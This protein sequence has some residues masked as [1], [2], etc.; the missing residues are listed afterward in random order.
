MKCGLTLRKPTKKLDGSIVFNVYRKINACV[1]GND[2]L[3]T[4]FD[5]LSA[6]WKE[7]DSLTNLTPCTCEASKKF[8]EHSDQI[9]L[10]QF[11]MGLDSSFSQVRSNILLREPL[12]S[13]KISFSIC[14]R[15]ES[16]KLSSS[17]TSPSEKHAPIGFF[18]NTSDSGKKKNNKNTLVCKNCGIKGHTIERCYKLIGYPKD[19]KG[20][21]DFQ[22]SNKQF[23]SNMT[24]ADLKES[25]DLFHFSSDQISKLLSLIGDKQKVEGV[26]ANMAGVFTKNVFQNIFRNLK[27]VI[28]SG[29]N[30]HMTSTDWNLKNVVDISDLK[31]K[32]DHPNGSSA[33]IVKIGDLPLSNSVTL[34]DVLVVPDFNVNLLSVHKVVKDNKIRVCFDESECYFQDLQKK[35]IVG[36]GSQ[37][38]GLYFID[39]GNCKEFKSNYSCLA[40]CYV[41]KS[42][43]HCRLGHPSEPVLTILQQ[44]LDI[45]PEL[46]PPCDVCHKAKQTRE[47][48]PLS[49]R[50]TS[51]LGDLIHLDVWGP[52]KV[53]TIEGYRYF[54]TVVDDFTRS[55][56]VFLLKSKSEV[57]G[58]IELFYNLLFT[59]FD[60]RIK[61]VRSDNGTEFTNN[62]VS[63]F[64]KDKG[65]IH[66]TTIAY[67]PQQNGIAERKHRHLLNVARSL[68]FQSGI[69]LQY[70]GDTILTAAYIINRTPSSVLKGKTLYEM[71]YSKLPSLTHLRIYG[72]LC[73]ATK[74]NVLN[75][76]ESRA[77]K[78]A[79]IGYSSFKKGYKLLSLETNIV[80]FSKDVQFYEH[81][82]PYKMSSDAT[83][84]KHMFD[85]FRHSHF[86]DDIDPVLPYD[87]SSDLKHISQYNN[88]AVSDRNVNFEHQNSD[89]ATNLDVGSDQE[90]SN[91][92]NS[93]DNP[94]HVAHLDFEGSFQN[95]GFDMDSLIGNQYYVHWENN[96]E[97]QPD[98]DFNITEGTSFD[99]SD[100][101]TV[102]INSD[103]RTTDY[104]LRRSSRVPKLPRK[105][106]DF[107]LD[108]KCKYGIERVVNYSHLDPDVRCFATN[109]NKSV[110]PKH[111]HE[112]CNDPNWVDAMNQEMNALYQNQTWEIT[113]LPS[114]RKPIGCKWIYKIKYKLNGDVDRYKA[115]LVAKEYSQ[116][117]G[118]D[119]D[120]TFAP[121]VKFV[122]I[123]CLITLAV[124]Q[125]WNLYQLD[126]NN[127]FLYGE[128]EEDVYMTL[129]Q[130][131][132]SKYEKKGLQT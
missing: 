105:L 112:A 29:A 103:P 8:S 24:Q 73:F 89:R 2:S 74:L 75:K 12:P 115:R 106:D 17:S 11:L 44:Y 1:Q 49:E 98:A 56:W 70:W 15:E 102:G 83:F 26:V 28:D 6:L 33:S 113:D 128:I 65:I 122:T 22:S 109:L 41:S 97:F 52:Y 76:F 126:I 21:N 51:S 100:S 46:L 62:N 92:S 117:E 104:D 88:P 20:K 124:N 101:E 119:F 4:Y 121:V 85:S 66:Q 94:D 95:S 13:V 40:K 31:L 47:S 9:K 19:N 86:F 35:M 57:F 14:S 23:S 37:T 5:K 84:S 78:C 90:L 114:G 99:N 118:I 81:I 125:S 50:K 107:V 39:E 48:F 91:S 58:N 27:W 93:L 82:L 131:Y 3:S 54:L 71:M 55:V 10:M 69:P 110:E 79:F 111:Y 18:A 42:T 64:F 32:V 45:G 30:H 34:F 120:E 108:G 16:H 59:Q 61:I 127:A 123:R 77:D 129:P 72:C 130:G 80:F 36:T 68:L 63:N 60:K 87:E 96:D 116:K 132:F 43:W 7:F 38:G 25:C 53:P 67:T